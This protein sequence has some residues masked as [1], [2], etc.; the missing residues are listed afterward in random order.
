MNVK[1]IKRV[2][3]VGIGGIGMS[4]LARFF[5]ERGAVVS[6]YDR[7]ETELT[8]RLVAEGMSVHYT[9]DVALCDKSAELV[10]YTPAIPKDHKEL[11]WYRDN[12]YPVFKRSDVLQWIT[13]AMFAVTVAGTHG[14]TTI[15]T[16]I[17]YLL[18]ETGAFWEL[19]KLPMPCD[20][21]QQKRS[22]PFG[23]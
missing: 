20:R 12:N 4:A 18:R 15:S 14:K 5:R 1:E 2:Y 22:Q 10:I 11:N 6:G 9:D 19:F 3:F 13:E 8:K 21:S 16:T 17:A 23:K 7:T